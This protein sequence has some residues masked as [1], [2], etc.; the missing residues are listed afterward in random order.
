IVASPVFFVSIALVGAA[1]QPQ[2]QPVRLLTRSAAAVG[3]A[4]AV[5]GY[6]GS[7]AGGMRLLHGGVSAPATMS[8]DAVRYL[9]GAHLRPQPRV[10]EGQALLQCGVRAAIDVS[11]GLVGDLRH[12]CEMSHVAARLRTDQAP[13]HPALAQLFGTDAMALALSGGEDYELLFTAPLYVVERVRRT[14]SCPVTVIGEVV[15]GVPGMVTL[16]DAGGNVVAIDRP[17]WDHFRP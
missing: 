12:I 15:A 14:L 10:A 16:L 7:S 3:D 1:P 13:V 9:T 8:L 6:V 5:T 4:I 17:G 2:G 11:D